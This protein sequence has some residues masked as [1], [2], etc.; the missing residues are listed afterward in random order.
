MREHRVVADEHLADVGR[1]VVRRT[2]VARSADDRGAVF[3]AGSVVEVAVQRRQRTLSGAALRGRVDRVADR[4]GGRRGRVVGL[5]ERH[6]VAALV[7]RP[8]RV[9]VHIRVGD[10]EGEHLEHLPLVPPDVADV[11]RAVRGIDREAERVAEPAR[12]HA[13]ANRVRI[14]R[15]VVRVRRHAP[16]GRRIDA[17]D[18]PVEQIEVLGLDRRTGADTVAVAVTDADEQ[19]T[20]VAEAQP[21]DRVQRRGRVDARHER[22]ATRRIRHVRLTGLALEADQLAA[23][24]RR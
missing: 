1:R 9:A 3:T 5:H 6:T 20:V 7:A 14:A 23:H 11:E 16:S 19:R 12:E 24:G 13:G 17:Q 10:R 18:L 22:H 8:T 2:Q 15:L 21:R 4:A